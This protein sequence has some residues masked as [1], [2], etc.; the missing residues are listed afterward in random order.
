MT[1]EEQTAL[2]TRC[3]NLEA[4][5]KEAETLLT[6]QRNLCADC[7]MPASWTGRRNAFL[8]TVNSSQSELE[9]SVADAKAKG[10]CRIC[11]QPVTFPFTLNYGKEFAHTDCLA[12]VNAGGKA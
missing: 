9:K 2:Q 12:I 11:K 3:A 8:A 4:L 6:Q 5:L 1:T 7:E 10:V